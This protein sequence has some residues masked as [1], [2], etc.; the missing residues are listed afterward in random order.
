MTTEPKYE[1]RFSSVAECEVD[2][3]V[4][5]V[6]AAIERD[7]STST[8][9]HEFVR[10]LPSKRIV[11]RRKGNPTYAVE[12]TLDGIHELAREWAYR[13]ESAIDR[14]RE[15][16]STWDRYGYDEETTRH[17]NCITALRSCNT[18]LAAHNRQVVQSYF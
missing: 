14:R 1:V 9:L 8:Y 13:A 12:L 3:I 7:P 4:D 6:L 15:L 11:V 10:A 5:D 18:V 16:N 17:R 2:P